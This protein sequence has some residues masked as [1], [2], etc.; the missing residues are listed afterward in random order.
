MPSVGFFLIGFLLCC[1]LYSFLIFQRNIF[2]KR[3]FVPLLSFNLVIKFF[4]ATQQPFLEDDWARYVWEGELI[5][6]GISPYIFPPESFFL[7]E[8]LPD[9]LTNILSVINHP[10]W[11][12]I[13]SPIV[14]LFFSISY[15]KSFFGIKLL[16]IFLEIVSLPYLLRI[17]GRKW[18][19]LFLFFPLYVKEVFWNA[20]FEILCLF[21]FFLAI[22]TFKKNKMFFLGI[23]SGV[24]ILIKITAFPLF[25]R[26][27]TYI[28]KKRYDQMRILFGFLF[29]ILSPMLLFSLLT[30]DLSLDF[31]YTNLIQF[32]KQF[33]FNYFL[34]RS[35][36][37][38]FWLVILFLFLPTLLLFLN[39]LIS[40]KKRLNTDFVFFLVS[41]FLVVVLPVNNAWYFL[42]PLPFWIL[43]KKRSFVPM[44]LLCIP[45]LSYLTFL[46]L[47]LASSE[48]Y[49]IPDNILYIQAIIYSI[50]LIQL[51]RK[52][53]FYFT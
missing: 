5:L 29:G 31:G 35:L 8:D 16:Y 51:N 22:Y 46:N 4:L 19:F 47:G 44:V 43:S 3:Y 21:S 24:L 14:L 7:I 50:S 10:D 41:I 18:V 20:H 15:P 49:A 26:L 42:I 39:I 23:L 12:S 9:H 17:L 30:K 38:H 32:G 48:V 1:A 52:Y 13:Y 36:M 2:F 27:L 45:Q 40:D 11:T 33:E 37:N 28:L 53:S 25:A 34:K 6:R